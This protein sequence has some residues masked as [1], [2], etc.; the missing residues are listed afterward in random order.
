MT[1]AE[2]SAFTMN[3]LDDKKFKWENHG[4]GIMHQ[5]ERLFLNKNKIIKAINGPDGEVHD[6]IVNQE[7]YIRYHDLKNDI[8]K[9]RKYARLNGLNE[10][11]ANSY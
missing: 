5:K 6:L 2:V 3:S 7:E 8:E 9:D 4:L 10:L 11:A 1:K